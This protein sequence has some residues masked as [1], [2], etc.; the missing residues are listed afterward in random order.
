[1]II[2]QFELGLSL[3]VRNRKAAKL[4][5]TRISLKN[6]SETRSISV[7]KY[8]RSQGRATHIVKRRGRAPRAQV[9]VR[10]KLM[11]FSLLSLLYLSFSLF[12]SLLSSFSSDSF[13][14]SSGALQSVTEE[15]NFNSAGSGGVV[16]GV[17]AKGA[18][19]GKEGSGCLGQPYA[20]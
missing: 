3:E 13:S 18:R 16:R 4:Q 10:G 5:N 20:P 6:L 7:R 15:D 17:G 19:G 1:M 9:G 12:L 11:I 2:E 14:S 8:L